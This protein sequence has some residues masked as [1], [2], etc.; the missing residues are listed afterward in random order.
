[1]V[2]QA[3]FDIVAISLMFPREIQSS[4]PYSLFESPVVNKCPTY[5]VGIQWIVLE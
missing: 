1:M 4:M 2:E 3:L 5:L